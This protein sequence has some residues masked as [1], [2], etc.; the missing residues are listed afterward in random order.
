MD[1]YVGNGQH[2]VWVDPDDIADCETLDEVAELIS[3]AIQDAFDDQVS[4]KSAYL[5]ED[6]LEQLFEEAHARREMEEDD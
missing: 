4:W 5:A 1:G 2:S 3:E 6:K